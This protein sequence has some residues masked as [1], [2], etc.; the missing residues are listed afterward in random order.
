MTDREYR[1]L[2]CLAN[3]DTPEAFMAIFKRVTETE[4]YETDMNELEK[5]RQEEWWHNEDQ[6]GR[7]IE[8]VCRG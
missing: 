8:E 7:F 1:E 4:E 6:N 5:Q 2:L 3:M